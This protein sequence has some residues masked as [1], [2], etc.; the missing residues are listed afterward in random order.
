MAPPANRSY[1]A[2]RQKLRPGSY[3]IV[4]PHPAID[5]IG[6]PAGTYARCPN[7]SDTIV[8]VTTPTQGASNSTSCP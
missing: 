8:E 5:R 4:E 3:G 7:G 6:V 1:A 2:R